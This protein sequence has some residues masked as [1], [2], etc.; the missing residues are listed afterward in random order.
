MNDNL[1]DLQFIYKGERRRPDKCLSG[2]PHHPAPPLF[3]SR[4]KTSHNSAKLPAT[5]TR[6]TLVGSMRVTPRM[7]SGSYTAAS[8]RSLVSP[9]SGCRMLVLPFLLTPDFTGRCS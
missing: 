1:I 2:L 8:E 5:E 3:H 6:C 9:K 7:A 4:K